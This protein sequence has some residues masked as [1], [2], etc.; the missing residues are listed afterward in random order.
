MELR[1]RSTIQ[2]FL[3]LMPKAYCLRRNDMEDKTIQVHHDGVDYQVDVHV[4]YAGI[5]CHISAE[6]G[7]TQLLFEPNAAGGVD[8]LQH[9]EGLPEGLI[10]QIAISV[11]RSL[12]L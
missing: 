2:S 5:D 12:E 1:Y 6:V 8:I 7:N 3:T 9:G 11:M 4:E 10:N